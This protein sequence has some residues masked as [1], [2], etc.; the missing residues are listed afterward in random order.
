VSLP[1]SEAALAL[2][3]TGLPKATKRP[4]MEILG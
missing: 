2:D 4:R 3:L 1:R